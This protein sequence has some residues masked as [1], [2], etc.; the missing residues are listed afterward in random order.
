I[1]VIQRDLGTG[2]L[3]FGLFIAMLYVATGKTSW[4]LIGLAMVV[5][6]VLVATQV[7]AYV[8]GRFTNW[9][10]AFDFDIVDPLD[11][12]HQLVQGIFGLAHGGLIGTGLGQG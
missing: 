2:M 8:R 10:Y 3:I 9:L 6:G 12:G 7:L 11:A 1:I 5:V 4:V